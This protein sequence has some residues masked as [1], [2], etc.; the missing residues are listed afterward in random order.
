M[1]GLPI[2]C[3]LDPATLKTRREGLLSEVVRLAVRREATDNGYRL[4]FAATDEA[5]ALIMRTMNAE[6]RCC[7]FLRFTLTVEPDEGPIYLDL[8]GPPGTA[9]FLA[10]LL[11]Q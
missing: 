7:R 2:A 1:S 9:S 10:G 8:T 3:T 11:D 4:T 6:R 5:L